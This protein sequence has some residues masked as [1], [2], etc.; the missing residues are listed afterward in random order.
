MSGIV[1][2]NKAV[3]ELTNAG[4]HYDGECNCVSR[5]IKYRNGKYVVKLHRSSGYAH[6][7]IENYHLMYTRLS[8]VKKIIERTQ[9]A[10]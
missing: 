10:A 2:W 5:I 1:E 8:D 6:L 3:N 7:F 4:F 9:E